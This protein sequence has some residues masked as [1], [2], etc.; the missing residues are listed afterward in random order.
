MRVPI[1]FLHNI[2]QF[3][4]LMESQRALCEVPTA[5]LKKK[6]GLILVF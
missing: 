4:F 5:S 1:I 3:M 6:I 2:T